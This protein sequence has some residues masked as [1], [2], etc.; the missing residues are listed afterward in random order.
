MER[1]ANVFDLRFVPEGMEF[2]TPWRDEA[3]E[4][5]GNYKPVDFKTDVSGMMC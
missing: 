4:D 5:L 2:D 1:T 3:T